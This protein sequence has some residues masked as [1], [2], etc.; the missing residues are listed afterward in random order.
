MTL[1]GKRRKFKACVGTGISS[2]DFGV[3]ASGKA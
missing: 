3:I 1:A 2:D